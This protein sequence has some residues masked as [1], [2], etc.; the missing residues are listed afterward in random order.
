MTM[1]LACE[2]DDDGSAK[3]RSGVEFSKLHMSPSYSKVSTVAF[4]TR[5][6]HCCNEPILTSRNMESGR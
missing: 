6:T 4:L 3:A 2:I 5:T 1:V